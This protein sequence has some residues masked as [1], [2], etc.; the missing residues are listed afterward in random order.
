MA[1]PEDI[2]GVADALEDEDVWKTS[3]FVVTLINPGGSPYSTAPVSD[4]I[5]A[6]SMI[7]AWLKGTPAGSGTI[8]RLDNNQEV[9]RQY[10][11]DNEHRPDEAYSP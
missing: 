11:P 9:F 2:E 5:L 6:R 10:G 8:S 4:G 7:D 1:D 3:R